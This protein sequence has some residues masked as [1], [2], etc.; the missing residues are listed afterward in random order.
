MIL[1][2][3]GFNPTEA[4]AACDITNVTFSP[5]GNRAI[6][7]FYTDATQPSVSVTLNANDC[8]GENIKIE[9]WNKSSKLGE[10]TSYSP[11]SSSGN[12][13]IAHSF[14]LGDLGCASSGGGPDCSVYVKGFVNGVEVINTSGGYTPPLNPTDR[15]GYLLDGIPD[16]PFVWGTP[17]PVSWSPASPG[18]S[19][20]TMPLGDGFTK[21]TN[22]IKYDNIPDVIRQLIKIVFTIG[23]PL[24]ALAII[25]AGFMLVTAGGNQEKI[26][27]GKQALLAAVIG[28]AILLGAWVIAEAIQG[29]VDQLRGV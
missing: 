2:F 22:P 18:N 28:G 27:K 4:Q 15:L 21:L 3:A 14:D 11:P 12:A 16:K 24:V 25:Y 6:P 20:G 9:V 8:A 13:G 7:G 17:S 1:G 23:I 10:I 19:S 5:G 29:T 26:K